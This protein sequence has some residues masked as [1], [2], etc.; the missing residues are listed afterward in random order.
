[1]LLAER[2]LMQRKWWGWGARRKIVDSVW[3]SSMIFNRISRVFPVPAG[4]LITAC[5]APWKIAN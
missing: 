4:A 1:M 3:A 2:K 5:L